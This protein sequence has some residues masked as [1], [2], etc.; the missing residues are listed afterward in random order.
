MAG[1]DDLVLRAQPWVATVDAAGTEGRSWRWEV[2][3]VTDSAGSPLDF[4][5]RPFTCKILDKIDG[6]LVVS[7][8]EFTGRPGGFTL[9]C[10][11]EQNAGTAGS[12]K[13]GSD[14]RRCRWEL[15]ITLPDTRIV[16]F[17]T[18]EFRIYQEGKGA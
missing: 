1:W 3:G 16:Q 5:G 11:K 6:A 2:Y 14:Y 8:W 15:A 13:R 10:N 18:G 7:L 9:S 12:A 17:W 4:T